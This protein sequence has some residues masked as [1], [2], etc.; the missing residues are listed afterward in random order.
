[1]S[2]R[3]A[4][5]PASG[6]QTPARE[7]ELDIVILPE[8][9]RNSLSAHPPARDAR[10]APARPPTDPAAPVA[11]QPLP[12][13][14]GRVRV[15]LPAEGLSLTADALYDHVKLRGYARADVV[16]FVEQH[17]EASYP[18]SAEL[19]NQVRGWIKA[20]K[21]AAR[22][23]PPGLGKEARKAHFIALVRTF[24]AQNAGLYDEEMYTDFIT[25]WTE[26]TDG[27]DTMTVDRAGQ[28]NLAVRLDRSNR[29]IYQPKLERRNR[30]SPYGNATPTPKQP[31][32][33][34]L[35]QTLERAAEAGDTL[36]GFLRAEE[37]D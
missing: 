14:L 10:S 16:G 29:E 23:F 22:L 35:N 17:P 13:L 31:V 7:R 28:F 30:R 4:D 33:F 15:H 25:Y 26:S 1:M 34:D 24:Q 2:T 36:P 18:S 9:V 12:D 20:R 11:Y 8:S 21:S 3:S 32:H 19:R 27:S 6:A 37:D 5:V